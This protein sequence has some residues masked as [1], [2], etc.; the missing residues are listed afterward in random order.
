MRLQVRKLLSVAL[1]ALAAAST[2]A[3]SQDYGWYAGVGVGQSNFDGCGVVG[4]ACFDDS[5]TSLKVFGGYQFTPNWGLEVGFVDHGKVSSGATSI[6]V[7]GFEVVGVGT[8]PINPQ[9][10]LFGKLGFFN[11]DADLR[12]PGTSLSDSGTDLTLGLGV[13]Y[14]FTKNLFGRAEWQRYDEVDID[15]LG[16][17][18]IFKF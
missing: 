7:S 8:F 9:F 2:P 10:S 18:V 17:S 11:W 14:R 12:T 4:S 6:D 16:I 1:F 3:L 5:D 15:V 13:Q